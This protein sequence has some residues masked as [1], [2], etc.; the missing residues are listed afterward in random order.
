MRF[1]LLEAGDREGTVDVTMV[2]GDDDGALNDLDR[3]CVS[4]MTLSWGCEGK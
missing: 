4:T 2:R 1:L 3:R